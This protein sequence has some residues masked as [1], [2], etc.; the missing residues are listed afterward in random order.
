MNAIQTENN[1]PYIIALGNEPKDIQKYYVVVEQ[2]L[3]EVS[4]R[5]KKRQSTIIIT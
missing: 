5:K 1:S 4:I 2:H 3:I